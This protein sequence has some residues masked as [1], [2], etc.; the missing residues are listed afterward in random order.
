MSLSG[1]TIGILCE[2]QVEDLEFHFPVLRFKEEGCD[3]KII[4]PTK[5]FSG[6][7]KH[8]LPVKANTG[9]DEA[10][11]DD[12]DCLIIPGGFAPDFWR[13]D[14]RFKKLVSDINSQGKPLGAICHGP[15]MLISAKV[16]SGKRMTCFHAI[17]DDVE[18]AGAEYVEG[19]EVVVDGNI[20]TSRKPD[21]LPAFC[22]A[23][24]D[25]LKAK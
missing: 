12:L 24:M 20:V 14:D 11:A 6:K 9:I 13:R 15:W 23:L 19:Q 22:R 25:L 4:G 8:G 10:K 5:D 16:A 7:G 1:R 21:D 2:Y 17:K 3:I 18:N